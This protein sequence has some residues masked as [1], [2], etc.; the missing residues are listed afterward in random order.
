[1]DKKKKKKKKEEDKKKKKIVTKF[2]A[3]NWCV[4]Y[5]VFYVDMTRQ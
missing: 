1:M 3:I 5:T 4:I 2:E